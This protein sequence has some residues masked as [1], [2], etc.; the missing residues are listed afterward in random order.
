MAIATA[1]SDD[2]L[3]CARTLIIA[4][5]Y[6]GFSYADIAAVVGIRKASIHHHFP[7][8]L[9][10]VRTLV[11]RYREQVDMGI[12]E[13]ERRSPDAVDQLRSYV[14][15]W[16]D[17][18]G[19]PTTSFCVCA[20]LASQIPVL[21][22]EIVLELRAHFRTLSGWLTSVLD[23]GVKQGTIVLSGSARAEAEAFLAT[24]HGAM[25]SARAYGEPTILEA[26]AKPL[27][28]RLVAPQ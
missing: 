25:L 19:D 28:D 18:I 3:G 10:L 23:R 9:D 26:I 17:C 24:M 8:K 11:E 21:P 12:A 1:T 5:G 14:G 16:E 13:F 2:I 27:I 7:T 22:H 4:G 20:L 15:F 6:N